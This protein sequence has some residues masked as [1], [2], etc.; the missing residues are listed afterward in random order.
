MNEMPDDINAEDA[1]KSEKTAQAMRVTWWILLA[2]FGFIILFDVYEWTRGTGNGLRHILSPLGMIC[3]ALANIYARRNKSL[4]TALIATALVL[5][6]AGL[7]TMI[8]Y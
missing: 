2:V 1:A 5:V 6:I 3:V 7:V 8:I 4:R